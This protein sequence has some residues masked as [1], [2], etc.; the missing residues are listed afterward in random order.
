MI[1]SSGGESVMMGMRRGGEE[2]YMIV[3]SGGGRQRMC[4]TCTSTVYS[5]FLPRCMAGQGGIY[6]YP[7]HACTLFLLHGLLTCYPG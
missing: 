4:P 1:G 7:A 5:S 2:D 6:R 3:S